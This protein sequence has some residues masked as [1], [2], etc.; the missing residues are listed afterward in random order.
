MNKKYY[1]IKSLSNQYYYLYIEFDNNEIIIYAGGIKKKC[2]QI[3]INNEG[4]IANIKMVQYDEKC[5]LKN[6]LKSGDE[7]VLFLKTILLFTVH[8]FPN[9]LQYDIT[10]NSFILCSD[11]KKISLPDYYYVKYKETWYEKNLEA[12]PSI[13]SIDFINLAKKNIRKKLKEQIIIINDSGISEEKNLKQYLFDFFKINAD[14]SKYQK[15]FNKY[16]CD[17]LQGY[18]WVIDKKIIINYNIEYISKRIK[19]NINHVNLNNIIHK[20]KKFEIKEQ[21]QKGGFMIL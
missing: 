18:T 19:K 5:S 10:D 17:N 9:I 20:L 12:I 3:I 11:K 6:L 13:K 8:H 1:V 4:N 2:I 15:I 14:C 21:N 7:M 16:I